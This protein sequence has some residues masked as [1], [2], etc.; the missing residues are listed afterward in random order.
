MNAYE[1]QA[2]MRNKLNG[3]TTDFVREVAEQL[4]NDYREGTDIA[5]QSALDVLQTR[6]TEKEFS[7]FCDS[8]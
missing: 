8:L 4:M 6:M 3:H 2:K 7:E 5:L 1:A